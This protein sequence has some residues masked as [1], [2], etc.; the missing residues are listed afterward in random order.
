MNFPGIILR[1]GEDRRIK[2]GHQWVF[3]NEIHK[4]EGDPG[5]GDIVQVFNDSG[6]SL[7]YGFYNQKS[8][9]SVRLFDDSFKGNTEDYVRSKIL[10]AY[11]LRKSCYPNRDSFRL[12]FS[13]SDQLPGLI[14]DKYNLTFVLQINS[15]GMEKN[16]DLINSV[17]INDFDAQNIF[18]RN[19]KYFRELEHLPVSDTIYHGTEATE[20][21]TDGT[22]RYEVDFSN[23]QKTGFYFDQ[24]DNRAFL[25]KFCGGKKVLDAFCNQGGF[26]LN[27]VYGLAEEVVFVDSSKAELQKAQKNFKLNG[28]QAEHAF[29]ESDV[30]DFLE[31][32]AQRGETYDVIVIDPPAFAKNKKS[33]YTALKGYEKLNRMALSILRKPGILATSSCSYHITREEFFEVVGLAGMKAKKNLRLIYFNRASLDH[34]SLPLMPETSYLKF[35][36]YFNL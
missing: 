15:A 1:H 34:P 3:S 27:A 28:F 25:R 19:E 9:I 31:A 21:I 7:G 13:E 5:P 26:G 33:K 32:C 17:L 6:H 16:I 29:I 2:S 18:T 35:A 12:V 20:I 4:V 10:S 11:Q 36:V 14:I 24:C 30:F 8:L 23:S 22:I